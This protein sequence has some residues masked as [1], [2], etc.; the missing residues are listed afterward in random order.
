M[1]TLP[2]ETILGD[3]Q[4]EMDLQQL[5][6]ATLGNSESGS[7]PDLLVLQQKIF[8]LDDPFSSIEN[9]TFPSHFTPHSQY[10]P[11]A[12]D[13]LFINASLPFIDND[14]PQRSSW[15]DSEPST[16]EDS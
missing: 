13:Q 9:H 7:D 12:H 3:V 6:L 8:G 14:H 10:D 11:C 5:L 16:T 1:T 4:A 15:R 2:D